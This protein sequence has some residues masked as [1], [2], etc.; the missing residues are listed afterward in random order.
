LRKRRLALRAGLMLP[1]R[2][3]LRTPLQALL[4][5]RCTNAYSLLA[6]AYCTPVMVVVLRPVPVLH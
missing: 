2:S 6:R 3:D 5:T 1:A 4:R